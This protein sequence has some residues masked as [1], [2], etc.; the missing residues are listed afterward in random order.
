MMRIRTKLLFLAIGSQV[1]LVGSL[2]LS[3]ALLAPI[4]ELQKEN[5]F[6]QEASRKTRIVQVEMNK[7]SSGNMGIQRK[8][9]ETALTE[10]NLSIDAIA[11][12][13]RLPA[14]N[15]TMAT[16][17][18]AVGELRDL[19]MESLAMVLSGMGDLQADA[20][21]MKL[22]NERGDLPSLLMKSYSGGTSE[23]V[24]SGVLY[25]VL[26]L[27]QNLATAN[28]NLALTARLIEE[29]DAVVAAEIAN[30]R[31]MANLSVLT[32]FGFAILTVLLASLV[33]ATHIARSLQHLSRNVGIMG[34]GDLTRRFGL[35]RKDEIG[36]LGKDLDLLLD[37]FNQSLREIQT[38]SQQ[39]RGLHKD[40]VRLV[41]ESHQTAEEIKIASESIR[42]QMESMNQRIEGDVTEMGGVVTGITVFH[43]RLGNQDRQISESV[44]AVTQMLA[45]IGNIHGIT[46]RDREVTQSLLT[47]SLQS[48]LV[49]DSAF[50]LIADI[51]NSVGEVQDV[52]SVIAGIA[53]QTNILA[54][55][56]AIEA[57]HAGQFGKGFAVVA[58]EIAKLASASAISSQEIA[59]TIVRILKKVV[60]ARAVR[61]QSTAAMTG[62]TDKIQ[63]V[64]NSMIEIYSNIN[65]MQTGSQ[66]ILGTMESLRLT[67]KQITS[68]SSHIEEVSQVIGLSMGVLSE[69]SQEVMSH[70]TEI[71]DRIERISTG[72]QTISSHTEQ[73]SFIG[74]KLDASVAVFRTVEGQH[75]IGSL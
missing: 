51:S 29:K 42:T 48:K 8:A 25:H 11:K 61:E 20:E 46:E 15:E 27:V 6:F 32:I 67:S 13:T 31:A 59:Q 70:T 63:S 3:L 4:E 12:L 73:L 21:N 17:V 14:L 33:M 58:D 28:D 54:L 30:I 5:S 43:S 65:E 72:I 53:E 10:Y 71:T 74:D 57:A 19:S 49:F 55:N 39:N 50:E 2:V 18:M 41:G 35:K 1:L 38:V 23:P 9:F 60:E 24:A 75:E 56:A 45:S 44:A 26:R 16:A 40:L 52:V 69:V 36:F 68:E 37:H 62:I 64:S 47:E 66:Q 7:L 22:T 34:T